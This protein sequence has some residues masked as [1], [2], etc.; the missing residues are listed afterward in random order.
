MR[1]L[2]EPGE[3]VLHDHDGDAGE[4]RAVLADRGRR[5]LGLGADEDELGS[6][7]GGSRPP[8]PARCA[9]PSRRRAAARRRGSPRGARR[10][11][12]PRRGGRPGR[13]VRRSCRRSRRLRSLRFA[14][15]QRR[16]SAV[17]IATGLPGD[18][19]SG[20]AGVAVGERRRLAVARAS[21]RP[22][23]RRRS[24]VAA[25]SAAADA[26]RAA[27]A[28]STAASASTPAPTSTAGIA[29]ST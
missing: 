13:A 1:C 15:F 9:C 19:V 24:A 4:Q 16:A 18:D 17:R 25:R 2:V 7:S 12:S 8:R 5:I 11:P 27:P 21:T 23:R 26:R 20:P 3:T 29:A 14:C 28:R 22:R 6:A 10:A